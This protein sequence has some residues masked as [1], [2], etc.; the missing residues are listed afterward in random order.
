MDEMVKKTQEWLDMNY[1]KY[2]S[3]TSLDANGVTGWPTMKALTTALQIELKIQSPTGTFGPATKAAFQNLSIN[4]KPASNSEADVASLQ[5]KIYILQGALFCKGYNPTAM[6]GTFGDKTEAAVKQL[7]ADAGIAQTGIVDATL[8]KALLTMDA[9]TLLQYGSYKGDPKIRSIQ[10]ALN[11]TYSSNS[12]FSSDIGLV[13]CDGLYGRATN[14]A[15]IYAI[16]IEEGISEPTGFVGS[17]TKA[18]FPYLSLGVQSNAVKILQYALYCYDH[19]K[20]D[21][22][23][24][25]GYYG[26][27]TQKAVLAFQ[28]FTK[29]PTSA[30]AGTQTWCSLLTSTGDNTRKGTACDCATTIT[31]PLAQN[32]KSNGYN[33]VGRYL[34]GEYK[35]TNDEINIIL[36]NNLAILP[37]FEVGGNKLNYFNHDQ[38][39]TDAQSA[40][41]QSEYLG[42]PKNA[43][44]YFAVDFDALD[45][46]V[47]S[48]ILPY[49]SG[50]KE[51]FD[52]YNLYKIGIYAPRNVCSR[53]SKAGYSCSSFVCDMSTGFSGNLGYPLPDDWA[54]DQIATVT[55]HGSAEADI[56]NDI[57]SGKYSGVTSVTP[58]NDMIKQANAAE[59]SEKLGVKFSTP[60]EVIDVLETTNFKITAEFS[61]SASKGNEDNYITFEGGEFKSETHQ[62][63][64]LEIEKEIGADGT[65][66]IEKELLKLGNT[67]YS[68]GAEV[69]D[70]KHLIVKIITDEEYKDST[71]GV[72]TTLT[73]TIAV[74]CKIGPD[75]I[76]KQV[77]VAVDELWNIIKA[78][79]LVGI[80]ILAAVSVI[81]LIIQLASISVILTSI[82]SGVSAG[83]ILIVIFI[84]AVFKAMSA[85]LS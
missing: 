65:K 18:K 73:I 61:I 35:L 26:N 4:S 75:E 83:I 5:N 57:S 82:A 7:Q 45:G 31:E 76:E 59:I 77:E 80:I 33:I 10:Q 21:P 74:E 53:V 17:Q 37:I 32:I 60:D 42:I 50:I 13:P 27:G 67:K 55:L 28:N 69:N 41:I 62:N 2:S 43:I 70:E 46:D 63:K 39:V 24:F 25:T 23:G 78:T 79:C 9:F 15:L 68:I 19:T 40:V 84:S 3:F 29:L 47:T 51:I 16:Q 64:L 48:S 71:S 11:G 49:F 36:R 85:K 38:G 6:T 1:S 34:T 81:A 58:N 54:F 12:Y 66:A 8:M 52:K 22:T 56:D 72:T 30:N 14:R 44:I 20:F